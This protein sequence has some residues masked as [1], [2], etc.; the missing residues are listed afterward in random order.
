MQTHRTP[1]EAW[2][3]RQPSRLAVMWQTTRRAFQEFLTLP[4]IVVAAFLI[5]AAGL[6]AIER[7]TPAWLAPLHDFLQRY[8]FADA[9]STS[10]LLGAI[11]TA[12][13][14]VTSITISLLLV[15]VQQ[16]AASMTSQVFDQF[17]RRRYNQFYFGFLV[18][19]ALFALV[20]LTT[21]NKPFNPVLAAALAS[22]LTGV[23]LAL[24]VALLYTTIDQMRPTQIMSAIHDHALAAR[25]KQR[26]LL[27][28]TRRHPVG[29]NRVRVP[30]RTRIHGYVTHIDVD[31]IARAAGDRCEVL[32]H[33]SL[34]SY[35][36]SGDTIAEV[37][38]ET[39][40][41]AKRVVDPV[42]H[43]LR[44]ERRRDIIADPGTGVD[45]LATVGWTTTSSAKSNPGPAL[46]AVRSLRDLLAVWGD[47]A[48]V[49]RDTGAR[50]TPD[51]D[52]LPIV[53][54]DTVIPDL[55]NAFES[56]AVASSESMQHRMF[57]AVATTFAVLLPRFTPEFQQMAVT[58][59]RRILPALGDHVLTMELDTAL[60]SLTAAL[61]QTGHQEAADEVE[62]ARMKLAATIGTLA[63]RGSRVQ[64]GKGSK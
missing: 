23:A 49:E 52:R 8:F 38:A 37:G 32:L 16:T 40:D 42:L 19:L 9:R 24:L 4:A 13:I 25:V 44:F 12:L 33:V 57:A 17:L 34:G 39:A 61:K 15:A 54:T 6:Y 2:Q 56:L 29:P 31:A 22:V 64:A 18:G 5:L 51:R 48:G 36:A 30:V 43:A 1:E 58:A 28:R 46:E 55:F 45:E 27:R 20:T 47:D 26:R 63:S 41:E 62:N 59:I 14:T 3:A 50:E 7:A 35:A 53:Y 21:V 11:A 10:D 60:G